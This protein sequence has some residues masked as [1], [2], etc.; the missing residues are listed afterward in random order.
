MQNLQDLF[1]YSQAVMS[2]SEASQ[3]ED[4]QKASNAN[5]IM[6]RNQ[7]SSPAKA[8]ATI[9]TS[10]SKRISFDIN[11]AEIVD[12]AYNQFKA[13]RASPKK[14]LQRGLPSKAGGSLWDPEDD[15]L[16]GSAYVDLNTQTISRDNWNSPKK[17]VRGA[18]DADDDGSAYAD[19]NTHTITQ[20]GIVNSPKNM[21]RSAWDADD[22]EFDSKGYGDLNRTITT[23]RSCSGTFKAE[24][25]DVHPQICPTMTFSNGHCQ[26]NTE[27]SLANL[28]SLSGAGT[29]R[30]HTSS[31]QDTAAGS[32]QLSDD[33]DDSKDDEELRLQEVFDKHVA[34]LSDHECME[35]AGEDLHDMIMYN[36]FT[37]MFPDLPPFFPT[38]Y[39]HT[40]TWGT[41]EDTDD[42]PLF[43]YV[44]P[45]LCDAVAT[46]L[47][48][49]SPKA[50]S[51]FLDPTHKVF[52]WWR[53]VSTSYHQ[54]SVVIRREGNKVTVGT[55]HNHGFRYIWGHYVQSII[56]FTGKW[57]DTY[58]ATGS[59]SS[60]MTK[61]GLDW[62]SF[63]ESHVDNEDL[64]PKDPKVA[65]YLGRTLGRW[66]LKGR[67]WQ[68]DTK[69][70]DPVEWM[71]DGKVTTVPRNSQAEPETADPES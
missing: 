29:V 47:F 8:T 50:L 52:E 38:Q 13:L 15:E 12:R 21:A 16:N 9:V 22:N 53:R 34:E 57:T 62:G 18:W 28:R 10:I 23:L 68:D 48:E 39:M 2:T 37:D 60:V 25:N 17:T 40:V 46:V 5:P 1:S 4:N 63:D 24:D 61:E 64:D 26:M 59:T 70:T 33:D 6:P 49:S 11:E 31:T 51:A 32:E 66:M 65:L 14:T 42:I 20:H 3:K 30:P 58:A 36:V 41:L 71:V 56:A 45:R 43:E 67:V 69:S 19:L 7:K 44:L 54:P 55:F 35:P 27:N